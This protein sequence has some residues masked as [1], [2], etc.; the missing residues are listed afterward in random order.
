LFTLS[1]PGRVERIRREL[2][3]GS[4]ADAAEEA[5]RLRGAAATV[6]LDALGDDAERLEL[7]LRE[8]D[9][10]KARELLADVATQV[11]RLRTLQPTVLQV[12]DDPVSAR[13]IE[14]A[15][16]RRPGVRLLTATTAA[17]GLRLARDERPDLLLVDVHLPD[18]PGTELV[19]RLRNDA[20]TRDVFVV[21]VTADGAAD[22]DGVEVL[23]KPV[24][25]ARLLELVDE[26]APT[27]ART[28]SAA[29]SFREREIIEAVPHGVVLLDREGC[30]LD[31][32]A[33][34]EQILGYRRDEIL[35]NPCGPFTHPDD[36]RTEEPLLEAVLA[37]KSDG[38]TIEKR[39]LRKNGEHVWARLEL[40][41]IRDGDG[42]PRRLLALIDDISE[43]RR[44]D[45]QV[46]TI[47][48]CI[49]DGFV[50]IDCDWR[51]TYVNARAGELL[52]RKASELI[53]KNIWDEFP[54]GIGQPFHAA[55]EQAMNEQ[56][57]VSFE[58]HYEP[59]DR[60]F[61][62]RVYGSSN[63]IAIY[64]TEVTER[65][66]IEEIEHRQR[67]RADAL[68]DMNDALTRT[69]DL[70]EVLRVLLESLRGF[71]PYTSAS[72]LLVEDETLRDDPLALRVID[73]G[74]AV[75]LDDGGRVGVPLRAGG[76][77]IGVCIVE[78]GEA[79]RFGAGDLD[80][81]EAATAHAAAAIENA[82]LHDELRRHAGELERRIGE[83]DAAQRVAHVGSFEWDIVENRISWSDELYRIYGVEPAAF[84]ATF[85][86][87][88]G[89]IHSDD[90]ET[91]T[92]TI[93]RAV[94]E[95]AP[96]RMQERI[97]RPDGELRYLE[98]WGEVTT[99]AEGRPIRLLGICHDV[100]DQRRRRGRAEALREAN[101][102]LTRTLDLEEVF[103][104]L[105][106]SL[107]SFVRYAAGVVLLRNDELELVVGASRG[108][109]DNDAV[110]ITDALAV[111]PVIEEGRTLT[112]D[113]WIASPLRAAGQVIG[114]C[115]LQS[116]DASPFAQ[117]DVEWIEALTA[118][119]A[120]AIENARLHD[121][122]RR[123][124][125]ELEHR[126]AERTA[127]LSRAKEEAERANRTK[128]DFLAGISH[129]L[130]TPM[131]A[132]LGFAQLL[133]LDDLGGEQG[134]NVRQIL[135][136]GRHLLELITELLD[137]ARIEAGELALSLEPVSVEQ[138]VTEACD[139]TR[140]LAD[141][142]GVAI[143][144]ATRAES[145]FVQADRQRLLQVLLNL[146]A[147]AVKYNRPE[148]SVDVQARTDGDRVSIGVR[149]TGQG[150]APQ[151][152]AR[153][154]EPFERL[155]LQG[156][157]IEGVGLGLALAQRLVEAMNGTLSAAST[158]GVGSS[159]TIEL[160]RA[161]DP[162][163]ALETD[164]DWRELAES[165]A[166][167]IVYIE[168]NL[169]NLQLVERALARQP[170]LRL[171]TATEGL[172][173]LK[174]VRESRPDLVLLDLHLPDVTGED[175]LERLASHPETASIPVV[176]VSAAASKGRVQRLRDGGARAYLTK[177][178]DLAA[179]YDVVH[180][181]L[182]E[183]T[184]A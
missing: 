74:R 157:T 19:H 95:A 117:E 27:D 91:V 122:L 99:N 167:T 145:T 53:G 155:G 42:R 81:L 159:F 128:S 160:P 51:Y 84:E 1:A 116:L 150:V 10:D 4:L 41:S 170:H 29:D 87:F 38:Y 7:T 121:Q 177:P 97:V 171:L 180:T 133:D 179:L 56:T 105:L 156:G 32:N 68:R 147:N 67:E 136:A 31:V 148:G 164:A 149:D 9:A 92:T 54:E 101:D 183:R 94:Q 137:I 163:D 82:R 28:P 55:Y 173:G 15:L 33:A 20:A 52:G 184:Q 124:A 104:I 131:N 80:W 182:D 98:S 120:A 143:S 30:V 181:V 90:R 18:A 125:E 96:F 118:Q 93:A 161:V 37:G 71:V 89:R 78:S 166:A 85:E 153:L 63:G 43:R 168:D 151:D 132:I 135:R 134:D 26:R 158:L 175:I 5:H 61:E 138:L 59:W 115:A 46:R 72:T 17:D 176:I 110:E 3:A 112:I 12:E 142:R 48:E 178:I 152:L 113:N 25:V 108:V 83:L 107:A 144:I 64:F 75:S 127:D 114:V 6:G 103:G 40:S 100:T 86:A 58:E 69:L 65:K 129:E 123:H 130:R 76:D 126:V 39:Y 8:L 11:E 146:L 162:L 22:V 47:L 44:L 70:D 36:H 34:T 141:Q 66:R 140:P 172:P 14:R 106:D 57:T 2:E 62:N 111:S 169:A 88:V 174:L 109:G 21:L 50:A 77:V 73:E 45:D 16:A 49:T 79:E 119:A 154:F 24:D 102:A 35:G 139:L 165:P 23:T 13:L 60:W